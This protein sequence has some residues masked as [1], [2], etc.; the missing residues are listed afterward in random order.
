MPDDRPNKTVELKA[1][2]FALIPAPHAYLSRDEFN[3]IRYPRSTVGDLA[4]VVFGAAMAFG[5]TIFA[6]WIAWQLSN[7]KPPEGQV[8]TWEL[9]AL[10]LSLVLA[11]ILKLIGR[12][13]CRHTHRVFK[14]LE[15]IF[16]P[17]AEER[18]GSRPWK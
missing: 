7:P 11:A 8:V 16:E 14:R 4:T 9:W 15:A 5:I 12:H 1:D 13:T 18:K 6:R 17:K 10:G 2:D 3:W